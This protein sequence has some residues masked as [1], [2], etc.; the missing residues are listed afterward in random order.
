MSLTSQHRRMLR[1]IG[2]HLEPVVMVGDDGLS[3]GVLAETERALG[4][5]ELI[6]IRLPAGDRDARGALIDA[7]CEAT[8]AEAIQ[9]IG[10]VAVLFRAAPR[11]DPR[12][13]N[14]LRHQRG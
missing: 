9:T 12:K 5:H 2:H 10:R 7:L 1:G 13:S 11:P 8:G 6:K 14:V 4:D 3:E